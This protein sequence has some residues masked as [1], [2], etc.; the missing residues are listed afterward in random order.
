LTAADLRAVGINTNCA[1]VLDVPAPG[2]HGVIGDRAYGPSA[3]EVA[4]LARAVAEGLMGGGVL[5]VMK[6]I[7]G[8]GRATADSHFDVPIVS[9]PREALQA[10]DFAPFRELAR[11]P[12]AMT[13]HVV[14]SAYDRD[15]PA[16]ISK[17]MTEEVIRG[18]IGFDGLL[19]S[20]DVA[21][22][23]LSGSIAERA[24]AVI[25]AGSDLVLA[26]N[27]GLEETEALAAVV[28]KLAGRALARF[29]RARAVFGQRQPFE[30]AE[31][32][33]CLAEVLHLAG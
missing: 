5:P 1:P 22:Q 11:L 8:H 29:D 15:A 25:A 6:H 33:A 17:R 9:A 27:G 30:V 28:P 2:S 10:V 4:A 21:M 20:D 12:A 23:A 31:A 32:E 3:Q 19:M 14:F 16:S 13:A 24:R 7:P 26:G 18:S